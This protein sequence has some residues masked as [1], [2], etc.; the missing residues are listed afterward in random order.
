MV[1]L[2]EFEELVIV[3]SFFDMIGEWQ[4]MVVLLAD[5]F[6]VDLHVV[7]DCLFVAQVIVVLH[8]AVVE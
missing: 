3:Q 4:I 8:L 5:G 7:E 6:V 2:L 1:E